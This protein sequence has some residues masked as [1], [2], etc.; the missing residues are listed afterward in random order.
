MFNLKSTTIYFLLLILLLS[1]HDPIFDF[2]K[3]TKSNTA[4]VANITTSISQSAPQSTTYIILSL[5]HILSTNKFLVED[6]SFSKE[7]QFGDMLYTDQ[8]ELR[9]LDKDSKVLYRR[10][11]SVSHE[12]QLET[13]GDEGMS[14]TFRTVNEV[15]LNVPVLFSPMATKLVI[16]NQTTKSLEDFTYDISNLV[17]G[18]TQIMKVSPVGLNG[19]A[20]DKRT[21]TRCFLRRR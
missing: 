14:S 17:N 19:C 1:F 18:Y 2:L 8:Y 7:P 6:I 5:K 13:F 4:A 21:H 11:F 12:Q 3:F 10:T 20:W 15:F 16:F 9:E